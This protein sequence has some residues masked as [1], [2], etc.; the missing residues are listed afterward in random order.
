[1]PTDIPTVDSSNLNVPYAGTTIIP[2]IAITDTT[3]RSNGLLTKEA[4][5]QQI[6][7]LQSQNVIPN[8][9]DA[10]DVY[11]TKMTAFVVAA[12][13][14]YEYYYGRYTYAL[15]VLFNK[16]SATYGNNPTLAMKDDIRHALTNVTKF[17]TKLNDILS[18]VQVV[19][20]NIHADVASSASEVTDMMEMMLENKEQIEQQNAMIKS[21]QASALIRKEMVK[22]TE[23]KARYN[24]NLLKVYSFLNIIALGVLLY[25]YKAAPE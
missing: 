5:N 15:T 2:D 20:A 23:E 7:A 12:R 11:Q 17:N 8:D 18:I 6:I 21:N 24:D 14:E 3:N 1:M 13:K 4:I 9:N 19:S 25:V 22:Y 10:P 16:I